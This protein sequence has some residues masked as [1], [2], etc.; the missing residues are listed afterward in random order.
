VVMSIHVNIMT[1]VSV[2]AKDHIFSDG[3]P[4]SP[5]GMM[6]HPS[7]EAPYRLFSDISMPVASHLTRNLEVL[8]FSSSINQPYSML[9][10]YRHEMLQSPRLL[11]QARSHFGHAIVL[12]SFLQ[13]CYRGPRGREFKA[14]A[15]TTTSTIILCTTLKCPSA[16]AA[17]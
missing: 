13:F 1:Y 14:P 12:D 8:V 15:R 17:C 9:V 16:L 3:K 6:L 11:Q 7:L 10:H 2:Q 5:C 4:T